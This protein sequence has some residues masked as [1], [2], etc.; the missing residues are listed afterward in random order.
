MLLSIGVKASLEADSPKTPSMPL[1]SL[2]AHALFEQ[3]VLNDEQEVHSQ[4]ETVDMPNFESPTPS[5][6]SQMEEEKPQDTPPSQQLI[7]LNMLTEFLQKNKEEET[8]SKK[9]KRGKSQSSKTKRPF[10]CPTETC[11]RRFSRSDELT[12][13]IRIHTGQKPFQCKICDRAFSR[14]DHLTTHIRTHTGEKP[15]TCEECGRK[16]ARSDERKRHTKIHL[17]QKAKKGAT[18]SNAQNSSSFDLLLAVSSGLISTTT[19]NSTSTC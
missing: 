14:S 17:K 19:T 10:I 4:S 12:R 9:A 5:V 16:F 15:F 13:H 2:Y 8:S 11:E 18:S 6:E 7:D 1:I 3:N